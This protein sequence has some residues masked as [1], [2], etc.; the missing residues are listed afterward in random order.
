MRESDRSRNGSDEEGT[1]RGRRGEEREDAERT[2]RRIERSYENKAKPEGGG[3]YAH[4]TIDTQDRRSNFRSCHSDASWRAPPRLLHAFT[5][6]HCSRRAQRNAAQ[7]G[8]HA[9]RR[10]EAL[11]RIS[12]AH[13]RRSR[14]DRAPAASRTDAKCARD[15]CTYL[16]ITRDS[17]IRTMCVRDRRMTSP[18]PPSPY[19]HLRIIDCPEAGSSHFM[20][21]S[22]REKGKGRSRVSLDFSS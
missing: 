20:R 8:A 11:T 16:A 9:A 3:R 19:V 13:I 5:H 7:R 21:N 14:H 15:G 22:H 1:S 2:G 12:A 10:P 6:T 18:T 4:A 17:M